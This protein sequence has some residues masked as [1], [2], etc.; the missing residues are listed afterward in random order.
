MDSFYTSPE[1]AEQ[2]VNYV[3][4]RNVS[5]IA[6][7]CV[8]DGELL[9]AAQ[10]KWSKA[11][12]FATDISK[13]ALKNVR[14]KHPEWETAKCDFLS[15]RS[16]KY[17]NLLKQLK[18]DLVLLNPPFSCPASKK[19]Y[20]KLDNQFF[21]CST[22]MFFLVESLK[23]LKSEGV[24]Y[25]IL[26]SSS[27]YSE[28]D[29]HLW[30]KLVKEYKLKVLDQ[31]LKKHFRKCSPRILLVSINTPHHKCILPG[32]VIFKHSI[33]NISI[34]R[35]KISMNE[36]N[37]LPNGTSC[38]IHSTNLQNNKI[39]ELYHM[40]AQPSAALLDLLFYSQG[41][42]IFAKIKYLY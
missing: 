2:L 9:R 21:S 8:G 39:V 7:F 5:S 10:N 33:K 38:L 37:T 27:A 17:C 32:R 4:K 30:N 14:K 34:F 20:V 35:G 15:E 31:P 28:K 22:A 12:F 26:P 25:A 29:N 13:D 36:L 42:V 41:L 16:Q 24:I 11:Q 23:Y 3:S 40:Y 19:Y 18:V 6:D 1:L